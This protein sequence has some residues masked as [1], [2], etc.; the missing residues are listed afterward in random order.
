[1]T[2]ATLISIS[3]MNLAL[4]VFSAFAIAAT[5]DLFARRH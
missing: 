3:T 4:A 2:F 1:M 5:A